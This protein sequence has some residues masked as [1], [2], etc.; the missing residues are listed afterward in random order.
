MAR[1]PATPHATHV[2][3]LRKG[4]QVLLLTGKDAGKRGTV[5]RMDKADRVLIEGINI[6]KR[7]TKAQP[8]RPDR[9]GRMPKPQQGGILEIA[10]PVHVSN[11]MIVCRAC[12]T[13]T[14]VRHQKAADGR[15]VR[16]CRHC[17]ET[18]TRVEKTPS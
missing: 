3:D 18:L 13:P 12:D 9:A 2:P 14:R 7:H 10:R 8:P 6:A 15:S 5:E 17:G 11:V 1:T 4:D 16:I